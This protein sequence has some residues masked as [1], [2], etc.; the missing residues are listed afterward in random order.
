MTESPYAF[1]HILETVHAADRRSPTAIAIP[2]E[3]TI[4]DSWSIAVPKDASRLVHNVARDLQDY[5]QVSMGVSL[6]VRYV[7]SLEPDEQCAIVVG[8]TG[9]LP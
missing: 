7:D 2:G 4:D 6:A 9:D 8:V 5:F 3:I 1:R